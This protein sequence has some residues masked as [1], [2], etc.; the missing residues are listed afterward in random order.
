MRLAQDFLR[1]QGLVVWDEAPGIDDFQLPAAPFGLAVDAVARD[2][3]LVGDDGTAGAGQTIEERGLTHVG[4]ADDH[5]RWEKACHKFLGRAHLGAAAF[6]GTF[7][8]SAFRVAA[9]RKLV[10]ERNGRE[11]HERENGSSTPLFRDVCTL[12]LTIFCNS[13][14][15]EICRAAQAGDA[16]SGWRSMRICSRPWERN[17]D[18]GSCKCFCRRIPKG[19]WLVNSRENWRFQTRRSRIIWTSLRMRIWCMCSGRARSCVTPQTRKRF[20]NCCSFSIRNAAR[21]TKRSNH[22]TL[23]KSA[24]RRTAWTA[25]ISR[26]SLSKNTGRR[27]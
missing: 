1:D 12:G 17:R 9:E 21:G 19:W 3:R 6:F 11:G 25:P 26:K 20:K 2:A 5:E 22:G 7:K 16:R 27:P 23:W 24:S 4:A 10:R 8:C 13:A 14:N 15:I 18:C